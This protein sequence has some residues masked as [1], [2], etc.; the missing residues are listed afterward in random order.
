MTIREYAEL[1][2]K[3]IKLH[4]HGNRSPISSTLNCKSVS[5]MFHVHCVTVSTTE[6]FVYLR[7]LIKI[8]KVRSNAA[9]NHMVGWL[10]GCRFK[11]NCPLVGLRT[12]VKCPP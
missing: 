12:K 6:S 4:S 1:E 2:K 9:T 11:S 7:N 10:V 3:S 8:S 5:S